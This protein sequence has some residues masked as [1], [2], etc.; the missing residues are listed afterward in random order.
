MA[1][2][3]AFQLEVRHNYFLQIEQIFVNVELLV[4]QK[5]PVKIPAECGRAARVL[6]TVQKICVWFLVAGPVNVSAA[7]MNL[8][9]QP[10]SAIKRNL[11]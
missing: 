3:S 11:L 1:E 10:S 5:Q 8:M 4:K 9:P 7:I 2:V 6:A